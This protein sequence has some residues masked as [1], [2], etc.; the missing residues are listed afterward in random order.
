MS[1]AIAAIS[2]SWPNAAFI[3]AG[4]S[5]RWS[6]I[7]RSSDSLIRP[8]SRATLAAK[9]AITASWQVK[10]L[11]EATPISGPAWVGSSRSTSRDIELVGGL[12]RLG[13]DQAERIGQQ[14]RLAVAE[15]RRDIDLDRD[16]GEALQPVLADH[17]DVGSGAAGDDGDSLAAG[18]VELH[19]G[20]R[21]LLLERTQIGLQRLGDDDRLLEYLLLHVMGMVALVADLGA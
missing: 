18:E 10:A 6:T 1:G 19:V 13:D 11:V 5:E 4:A 2:S 21:D 20:Q 3:A 7:S 8:L 15:L 14:D 9:A 12:A 16:A 17:A